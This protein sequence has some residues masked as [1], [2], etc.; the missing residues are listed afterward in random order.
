MTQLA[1]SSIIL[2]VL[3]VPLVY[4]GGRAHHCQQSQVD[5]FALT[6]CTEAG[7]QQLTIQGSGMRLAVVLPR[8][9]T[10][11]GRS[12]GVPRFS[13]SGRALVGQVA[14]DMIALVW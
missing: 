8:G 2:D 12:M 10:A 3:D 9:A 11:K 1:N 7:A 13:S 4:L 6:I 14:N 5:R